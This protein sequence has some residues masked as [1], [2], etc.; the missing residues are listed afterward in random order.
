MIGTPNRAS[1]V[2][3]A[4]YNQDDCMPAA[5]D[6]RTYSHIAESTDTEIRNPHTNYYTIAGDWQSDY[7]PFGL[8]FT[9][10]NCI[11]ILRGFLLNTMVEV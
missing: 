8:M 1:P 10:G 6:L 3:D 11:D 4:L 7:I 9:D 2:E 5:S